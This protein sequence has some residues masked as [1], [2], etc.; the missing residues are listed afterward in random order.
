MCSRGRT[1]G[2]R[3]VPEGGRGVSD[4]FQREDGGSATCSRGRTGGR[5]RV[6]EGGRGVGDVF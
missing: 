2:R 4:V 6:P 3:C 5:R 1:G